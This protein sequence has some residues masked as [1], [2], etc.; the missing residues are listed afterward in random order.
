VS[1][2]LVLVDDDRRFR[3]IARR[4]LVAEGVDI[5]AEVD[6]GTEVAAAVQR[7]CPDVVLVDIGLP[8]IDGTEVAR[9]LRDAG[10]G[11]AVILIS[12][13]DV[14][15]GQRLADGLAAGY[16][17]KEALSLTAILELSDP[18]APALS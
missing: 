5:V 17:P 6:N 1:V 13:R 4:A 2:R 11:A 18:A 7:W 8:D 14:D 3:A 9:R 15:E 16:L 12:T 10:A